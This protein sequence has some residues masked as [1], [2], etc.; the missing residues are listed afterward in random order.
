MALTFSSAR[1]RSVICFASVAMKEASLLE[2]LAEPTPGT[3]DAPHAKRRGGDGRQRWGG[4]CRRDGGLR[5]AEV[6]DREPAF[7][8]G[9][10]RADAVARGAGHAGPPAENR[11][12]GAIAEARKRLLAG[13]VR[14]C[15]ARRWVSRASNVYLLADGED[16]N[17]DGGVGCGR[18]TRARRECHRNLL[19]AA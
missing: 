19:V 6:A 12:L 4:G 3:R 2:A 11:H 18:A 17:A 10:R 9:V 5:E 1:S 13:V 8:A 14:Q 15:R 16:G 7:E